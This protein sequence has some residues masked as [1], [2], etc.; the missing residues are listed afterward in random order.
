QTGFTL[1]H[2]AATRGDRNPSE[3]AANI[4]PL[5]LE[6]KTSLG[7]TPLHI[8]AKFGQ[9]RAIRQLL[10]AGAKKDARDN[11][12]QTPLS[13]CACY[14]VEPIIPQLLADRFIDLEVKDESGRT[15]I[16]LAAEKGQ[17]KVLELLI[18]HDANKN[19]LDNSRWT[20]LFWAAY[21]GHVEAVGY[22][23]GRRVDTGIKDATGKTAYDLA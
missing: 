4:T 11:N 8:A 17:V 23:L 2:Y 12:N 9:E 14:D 20:P 1:L 3:V 5:Y 18:A 19:V 15:P 21:E 22:L 13:I 16:S 6:A 10:S 7:H